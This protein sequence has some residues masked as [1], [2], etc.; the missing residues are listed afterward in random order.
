MLERNVTKLMQKYCAGASWRGNDLGIE[1]RHPGVLM[2]PGIA[3]VL[4]F[5]PPRQQ[6]HARLQLPVTKPKLKKRDARLYED[7]WCQYNVQLYDGR[8]VR[9]ELDLDQ[10]TTVICFSSSRVPFVCDLLH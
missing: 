8:T 5:Q 7:V 3:A 6:R 4:C 1:L 2:L 10:E 9:L